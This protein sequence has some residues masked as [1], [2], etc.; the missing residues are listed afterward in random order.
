MTHRRRGRLVDVAVT[1][2]ARPV[3][4]FADVGVATYASLRVVGQPARTVTWVVEEPNLV[5]ALDQLPR[6]CRTRTCSETHRDAVDRA[7]ATGPFASPSAEMEIARDLGIA[8][9][10]RTARGSC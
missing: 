2:L 1:G 8:I 7:I 4:R 10:R 9:A 3:L 5:A 6:R